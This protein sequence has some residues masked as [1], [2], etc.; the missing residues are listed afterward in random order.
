MK[1]AENKES[2]PCLT[3]MARSFTLVNGRMILF[4]EKGN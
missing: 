3:R 1:E 4:G 2:E